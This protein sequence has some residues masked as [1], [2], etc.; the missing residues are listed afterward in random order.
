YRLS[1]GDLPLDPQAQIA[2]VVETRA[3]HGGYSGLRG[4]AGFRKFVVD[5]RGGLLD[6][7]NPTDTVSPVV[8]VT[9]GALSSTTL[10]HIAETGVWRVALDV[11]AEDD[12]VVELSVHLAGFGRKL[13]ED[14]LFQ[15]INAT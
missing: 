1:W 14:W 7:L 12:A 11:T 9:N 13:S 2:H 6:R 3:G 10:Q 15:W 8:S 5:F 4:T